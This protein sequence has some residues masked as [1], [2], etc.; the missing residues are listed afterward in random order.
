VVALSTYSSL[1]SGAGE[2]IRSLGGTHLG[3]YAGTKFSVVARNWQDSVMQK[4]SLRKFNLTGVSA[5]QTAS[6]RACGEINEGLAMR[7]LMNI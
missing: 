3:R 5:R 1:A 2:G 6:Y 4:S 7:L